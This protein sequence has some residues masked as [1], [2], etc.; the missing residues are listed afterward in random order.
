M[1]LFSI[2]IRND[3]KQTK[4]LMEPKNISWCDMKIKENESIHN[5]YN[6][7][8]TKI[9]KKIENDGKWKRMLM[10]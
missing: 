9:K 2:K 10:R 4:E 6:I 3:D 5:R 1:A 7:Y 8:F